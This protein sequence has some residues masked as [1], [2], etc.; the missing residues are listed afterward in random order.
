MVQMTKNEF[1]AFLHTQKGA[2][3]A[4]IQWRRVLKDRELKS[5][6]KNGTSGRVSKSGRTQVMLNH[7]Y[8]NSV[9]YQ[10]EREGKKADFVP[11][12]RKWGERIQGT[13]LVQHKGRVYLE[14]KIL[15]ALNTQWWLDS[16]PVNL[17]DIKHMVHDKS[18][19]K[20]HQGLD[21]EE[22]LRDWDIDNLEYVNML[23]EQYVLT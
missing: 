11:N 10:R 19:N 5:P 8:G 14:T 17:E 9:N 15:K 12:P 22:I 20:E 7:V 13:T 18:S 23:G 16:K 21:K 1:V 2:T 4:T 6:K 3:P